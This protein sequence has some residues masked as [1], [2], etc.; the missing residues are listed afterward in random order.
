VRDA[1]AGCGTSRA[2]RAPRRGPPEPDG[3]A[4]DLLSGGPGVPPRLRPGQC[5]PV[6]QSGGRLR[7]DVRD[8]LHRLASAS[9]E[10]RRPGGPFASRT[11]AASASWPGPIGY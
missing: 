11:R 6:L 8:D 5:Q 3:E 9:G 7:P 1:R 2:L 4:L 10:R